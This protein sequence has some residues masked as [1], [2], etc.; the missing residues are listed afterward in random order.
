MHIVSHPGRLKELREWYGR[1]YKPF[2]LM[3]RDIQTASEI[4]FV[5]EHEKELLISPTRP[6]VLLEKKEDPPE[7]ARV[8]LEDASPGLGNVGLYL[9]Y[10]GIHHLLFRALEEIGSPLRWFVM[11]SAN[12]PGEPMALSIQDARKLE[13]DGYFVHDR[14]ISAR[15]DDSVLVPFSGFRKVR[16]NAGP[17]GMKSLPIRR[18]RGMVPEPFAVPHKRSLLSMGAERNV[19]IS[20]ARNGRIFTSPYIGNTRHPEVLQFA[21][22]TAKRLRYLFGVDEIEAVV[23]DKHPRYTTRRL[24]STISEDDGVE[25]IEVQHH[26]AHGASLMVDASL[27]ELTT[28]VVD[29]VGYGDDGNPW[30][31]EVIRTKCEEYIRIGQ[32]EEFGL[33]GGDR[34]A[35]HPERI[36]YW[37]TQEAGDQLELGDPWAM[38]V[39]SNSHHR[40][41][42]T[43]SLGRVLDGLSSLM[44][45]IKERTYDGEPAI[46][47]E[48]LLSR[49]KTPKIDLFAGDEPDYSVDIIRRWKTLLDEV[50]RFTDEDLKP[51]LDISYDI[52]ADLSMG[53]VG[54]IIDDM[55][56]VAVQTERMLDKK[57][58]PMIGLSGGVSYNVPIATRF[59]DACLEQGATPVLHSRV[60]PGDGGISIRQ[61]YIARLLMKD[62]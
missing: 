20:V 3:V 38:E 19:S 35:Y 59:V 43:S 10:S 14:K 61:A 30:G 1:P 9:P 17:F 5:Q 50:R 39:L 48:K 34:A 40:A 47:L 31:G 11:T 54:S 53:F 32:L 26:H 21:S 15:C 27:D 37:L 8:P 56:R 13:A 7:W 46:R 23:I 60:P 45:G 33:P 28:I 24:G 57:S 18:S 2:A 51:G 25:L 49:S 22:D 55:V 42:M 4:A 16:A 36:A 6:I 58:K 12:P 41:V 44:L 52:K 29:G 62:A